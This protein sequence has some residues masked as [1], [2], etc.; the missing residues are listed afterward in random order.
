MIHRDIALVDDLRSGAAESPCVEFKRN[1]DDPDMIGRLVSALSNA[2][3]ID[4]QTLAY[5]VWGI[6]N[7]THGVV[8]TDF[9]FRTKKVGNQEFEL[10]L[11]SMLRPSLAISFRLVDH[12]EGR[13]VLCEIPSATNAPVEFKGTAYSV[14]DSGR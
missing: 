8:G 12:P 10:W 2:A 14:G 7:E 1:N 11:A 3:R 5:I 9:D 13:V 6:D 4:D